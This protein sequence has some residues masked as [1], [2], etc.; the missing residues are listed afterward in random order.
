MRGALRVSS[1]D[2]GGLVI[3]GDALRVLAVAVSAPGAGDDA[4][5]GRSPGALGAESLG[6][7]GLEA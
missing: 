5:R 4:A 2:G 6:R 7:P 3:A 1:A